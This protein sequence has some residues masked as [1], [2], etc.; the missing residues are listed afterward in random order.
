MN[1]LSSLKSYLSSFHL[2]RLLLAVLWGVLSIG[3]GVAFYELI[4]RI[5][6]SAIRFQYVLFG[7]GTYLLLWFAVL[8]SRRQFWR[9]FEHELTHAIFAVLSGHRIQHFRA[10]EDE[11]GSIHHVGKTRNNFLISLAPYFFPTLTAVPLILLFLVGPSVVPYMEFA[12]G[13]TL[14]YHVISTLDEARP[15]QPDL[16]E[17]GLVFSY[18]F[19]VVMNLIVLGSVLAMTGFGAESG[20][21]FLVRGLEVLYPAI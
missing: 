1:R 18:A 3:Y 6:R 9:T 12:V 8:R 15:R 14:V 7:M 2:R 16:Q 21:N 17:H 5:L 4:E 11:G 13:M 10:S 19:I 20:W